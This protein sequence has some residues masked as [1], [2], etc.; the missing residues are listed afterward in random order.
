MGKGIIEV[1]LNCTH[2]P[3]IVTTYIQIVTLRLMA[4]SL[5]YEHEMKD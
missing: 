1:S 2:K 4:I 3:Q 5:N